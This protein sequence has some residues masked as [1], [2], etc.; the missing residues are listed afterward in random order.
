LDQIAAAIARRTAIDMLLGARERLATRV[1]WARVR[2]ASVR[3]EPDDGAVVA[4]VA[5]AAFDAACIV[6]AARTEVR[7]RTRISARSHQ[8]GDA[9]S[10]E[11]RT[12][13]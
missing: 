8:R 12:E 2:A 9:P 7:R 10:D 13:Q 1:A 6:T 11:R 4:A 5:D 3:V